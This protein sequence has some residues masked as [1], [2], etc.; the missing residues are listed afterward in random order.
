MPKGETVVFPTDLFDDDIVVGDWYTDKELTKKY[1]AGKTSENLDLYTSYYTDGLRINNGV[2]TGYD[3]D[4]ANVIVPTVYNG[5]TVTSVGEYAFYRSTELPGITSVKLPETVS[6]IG[7]GAFYECQRLADINLSQNV[8]SI[9]D[10]AFYKNI[11]LKSVGDISGVEIIGS[12]AF[13]GCY[14]LQNMTLP[15]GLKAVNDYA[16]ND[17]KAF[18]EVTLPSTV[19]TVGE[20]S[21]SGCTSLT[22]VTFAA[23]DMR[24]VG[25]FAFAGCEKL[26]SVTV[27]NA[28]SRVVFDNRGNPF[29]KCRNVV[30]YVPSA[31]LDAYKNDANN[32]LFKDKF[33]AIG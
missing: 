15:D 12:G 3:G 18:T 14:V 22:T 2:V 30:I 17:C 16:F 4:S 33:A 32:T 31:Q 6:R 8:S 25:K 29:D 10:N 28:D 23:N 24:T 11:R 20:Y 27:N 9:G 1:T 21:F 7:I 26:K 13:N 5:N 19:K